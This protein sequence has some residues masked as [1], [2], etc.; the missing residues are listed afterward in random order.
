MY[1][2]KNTSG[3]EREINPATLY[4][5]ARFRNSISQ[6]NVAVDLIMREMCHSL[7][8]HNWGWGWN[9]LEF[10]TEVINCT[11][12][13]PERCLLMRSNCNGYR[14]WS[15][16]EDK[17][18]FWLITFFEWNQCVV[19]QLL[20]IPAERPPNKKACSITWAGSQVTGGHTSSYTVAIHFG[21]KCLF[22]VCLH[23]SILGRFLIYRKFPPPPPLIPT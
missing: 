9:C 10:S 2:D 16:K 19:N 5:L 23:K 13:W 14:L 8:F 11:S 22:H 15:E 1:V 3:K 6:L 7:W 4:C 20:R 18:Q 21:E 12:E 17:G